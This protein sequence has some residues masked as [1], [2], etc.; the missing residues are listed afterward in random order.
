MMVADGNLA[1]DAAGAAAMA[2]VTAGGVL[3]I[4]AGG[5]D[6]LNGGEG[7]DL[8]F[9]DAGDDK[10]SGGLG[11]DLLIGGVG[12]DSLRS[13]CGNDTLVGGAGKD[14]A[15][16]SDATTGILLTLSAGDR[17]G[18]KLSIFVDVGNNERDHLFSIEQINLGA[19]KDRLQ[20]DPGQLSSLIEATN[21]VID[22]GASREDVISVFTSERGV[23]ANF[24]DCNK[25]FTT[26]IGS[27]KVP[28]VLGLDG[29]VPDGFASQYVFLA[30]L[31][32]EMFAPTDLTDDNLA[33]QVRTKNVEDFEGSNQSDLIIGA[34]RVGRNGTRVPELGRLTLN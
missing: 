9:G 21:L 8:L 25:Q 23:V 16:Y 32:K 18:G 17:Y 19:G 31:V 3:L 11:D 30:K 34:D 6:T 5:K 15:D 14:V 1:A 28:T 10:L 13:G 27:N 12:D 29:K 4:G 2:T 26:A 24:R 20:Y 22:F 33:S 7:R